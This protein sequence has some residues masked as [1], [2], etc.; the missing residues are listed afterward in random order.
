MITVGCFYS[1]TVQGIVDRWVSETR[2][3][4]I[5]C[6]SSAMAEYIFR[7]KVL[8]DRPP[9]ECRQSSG[10]T[11]D[12]PRTIMDFCDVDSDKWAQ[13]A[14]RS[15]FPRSLLYAFENRTLARYERRVADRF[16][17]CVFVSEKEASLFKRSNPDTGDIRVIP[18]GV[19][20][21]YFDPGSC[22]PFAGMPAGTHSGNGAGLSP[23]LVFTGAM[24]YYA[25]EDG[26]RW[27]CREIFPR[28][29]EDVPG[30]RFLIVGRNPGQKILDLE[31]GSVK[32][33]GY[34]EDVRPYYGLA[35]V[36]VI[37]LRIA[38]GVQ[39]KVLESMAMGKAIVAAPAAVEGLGASRH[40]PLLLAD[41]A[42]EFAD[43][44]LALLK[45][46]ETAAKLGTSAREYVKRYYGWP[47]HMS[48]LEDV[49]GQARQRE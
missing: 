25:N 24:D 7:C 2:Y 6:F 8:Q 45:D 34:V 18:N 13:Y 14:K 11:P 28:I 20:Y 43:A 19:D 32:V 15:S 26:V 10:T 1:R 31:D 46:P 9:G 3:D 39:N 29:L 44:V 38:R 30:A 33:T 37:P 5:F 22:R 42:Q 12:R 16:D 48:K 49:I 35:D 23:T 17:H 21:R 36:C 41:S 47:V 27:F 40:R 4:A